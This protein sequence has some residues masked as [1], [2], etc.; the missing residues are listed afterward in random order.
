M[1]DI[2]ALLQNG[3]NVNISK[4]QLSS[5]PAAFAKLGPQ[6]SK[7]DLSTNA[8][9]DL[10]SLTSCSALHWL[11]AHGN[12][13]TSLDG[14]G[15]CSALL[16]LN[17]CHNRIQDISALH[18]LTNLC[19]LVLSD[20]QIQDI[21][22]LPVA[23]KL[24]NLVLSNNSIK[25]LPKSMGKLSSLQRL[26]LSKNKLSVLPEFP[27]L[28]NLEQLRL[29]GNRFEAVPTCIT[30][31]RRL[32]LLDLGNNRIDDLSSA[33]QVLRHIS[34]RNLSL[35]GNPCTHSET[36]SSEVAATLPR[37]EVFDDKVMCRPFVVH[38]SCSAVSMPQAA[39]KAEG[40]PKCNSDARAEIAGGNPKKQRM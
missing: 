17:A 22:F 23:P 28:G 33:L 15:S 20:N 14:I 30:Q 31:C 16:V 7:L 21:K 18:A 3:N 39:S 1:E 13:L 36:Y 2:E 11:D 32:R 12:L 5:L 9:V 4:R 37:L 26:S 34:L 35:R 25:K 27:F 19:S 40:K 8:L 24:N 6:F 38:A 29:N 10:S